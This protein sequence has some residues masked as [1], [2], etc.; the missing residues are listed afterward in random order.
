MFLLFAQL[1]ELLDILSMSIKWRDPLTFSIN[2]SI[3]LE[4]LELNIKWFS[5][6]FLLF[7]FLKNSILD[8]CGYLCQLVDQSWSEWGTRVQFCRPCFFCG[9]ADYLSGHHKGIYVPL[10]FQNAALVSSVWTYEVLCFAPRHG[11]LWTYQ[12][13]SQLF[14]FSNTC[15]D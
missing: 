13:R 11:G 8:D 14:S 1:Y 12:C 10:A 2:M 9:Y 6:S 5:I 15:V 3:F 4:H 7:Q